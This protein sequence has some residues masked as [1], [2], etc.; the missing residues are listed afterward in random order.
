MVGRY[1]DGTSMFPAQESVHRYARGVAVQA[2]CR[3]CGVEQAAPRT[4]LLPDGFGA[5]RIVLVASFVWGQD[6]RRYQPSRE[7]AVEHVLWVTSTW[8]VE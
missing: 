3:G 2:R 8:F 4:C 6:S 7:S 5:V 1:V